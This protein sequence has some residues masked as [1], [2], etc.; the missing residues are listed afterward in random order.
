ML[1][2]SAK[3]ILFTAC[4]LLPAC[5]T[6][7]LLNA[8]K[9]A[10][11][12]A[13]QIGLSDVTKFN[14]IVRLHDAKSG[15]FFCTGVVIS[16]F[17]IATA[18]HCLEGRNPLDPDI[19]VR[20]MSGQPTKIYAGLASQGADVRA[21]QGALVGDF[22]AFNSIHAV[23]DFESN[24]SAVSTGKH[25]VTC[26]Y[27]LSAKLLCTPFVYRSFYNFH[28]IGAG[29]LWGGQ[30]GGPVIDLETGNVVGTNFASADT[31]ILVNTL[32]GFWEVMGIPELLQKP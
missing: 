6:A 30:S 23:T 10:L 22:Q 18:G 17:V 5:A 14:A 29:M 1:T 20:P 24:I 28:F 16:R 13:A 7:A 32:G 21:D 4:L 9:P 8:Q 26:G 15:Q 31:E 12:T 3:P 19:E 11:R 2:H 27:P 25:L